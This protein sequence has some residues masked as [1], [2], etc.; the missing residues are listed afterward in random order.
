MQA[1]QLWSIFSSNISRE[2]HCTP[3]F[4]PHSKNVMLLTGNIFLV[5]SRNLL[6]FYFNLQPLREQEEICDTVVSAQIG[7]G[8]RSVAK[9]VVLEGR[10]RGK[11]SLSEC[12]LHRPWISFQSRKCAVSKLFRSR[13]HFSG[14]EER[15][16]QAGLQGLRKQAA[17]GT[18]KAW[19]LVLAVKFTSYKAVWLC[20]SYLPPSA[21]SH[22]Q[23]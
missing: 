5:S 21:F 19:V 18:G 23:N 10:V 16:S 8:A 11:G 4:S 14:K 17:F 1:Q 7:L 6:C 20:T 13:T 3:L 12:L 9:V 2:S 22:L 15:R